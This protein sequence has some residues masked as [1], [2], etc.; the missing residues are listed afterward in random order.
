MQ[1]PYQNY[2]GLLLDRKLNFGEDLRYIDDKV[3]TSTE[4]LRKL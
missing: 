1:F 4:L 2:L 3:D